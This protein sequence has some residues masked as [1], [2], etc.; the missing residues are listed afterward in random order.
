M[1]DSIEIV[2]IYTVLILNVSKGV[3]ALVGKDDDAYLNERAFFK[4][5]W[6]F[7]VKSDIL[8]EKIEFR[9][10]E[11][12]FVFD[13]K[14]NRAFRTQI[15]QVLI[16]NFSTFK[17]DVFQELFRLNEIVKEK[18]SGGLVVIFDSLEKTKD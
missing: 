16:D 14:E 7:L 18:R 5:I 4:R 6:D 8:L 12:K 2:E 9:G 17:K 1:N 15:R 11:F 13:V 3:A 10:D